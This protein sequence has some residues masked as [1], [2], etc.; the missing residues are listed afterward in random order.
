MSHHVGSKPGPPWSWAG[1]LA[2]PLGFQTPG[3]WR[4]EKTLEVTQLIPLQG[5]PVWALLPQIPLGVPEPSP[6][7]L[8]LQMGG[9]PWSLHFKET[10]GRASEWSPFLCPG[11]GGRPAPAPSTGD[12][13]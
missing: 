4:L 6:G 5:P 8:S 11:L 2:A 3:K 12:T 10:L 13:G 1:H 7:I 9:Q